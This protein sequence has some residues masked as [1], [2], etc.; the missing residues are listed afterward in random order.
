MLTIGIDPD[1]HNTGIAVVED[2]KVILARVISIAE[3]LKGAD[4]V[5][6]MA[7]VVQRECHYLELEFE[8]LDAVVVEGQEIYRGV[9]GNPMDMLRIAQVAGA[10]VSAWEA[11]V[12]FLPQPK[13]WKGSVPKHIHQKRTA[14]KAGWTRTKMMGGKSPYVVPQGIGNVAG[15]RDLRDSDWKHVMDAVG[16]AYWGAERLAKI[17]RRA[18]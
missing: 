15:A 3:N 16:L 9:T 8:V 18:A 2:G 14:A 10:A 11:S 5:I 6:E 12:T 17:R 4:A 7:Q 13:E 1:L